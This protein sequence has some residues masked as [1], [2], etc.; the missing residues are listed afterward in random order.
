MLSVDFLKDFQSSPTARRILSAFSFAKKGEQLLLS[1]PFKE[2][3]SKRMLHYFSEAYLLD[4][5]VFQSILVDRKKLETVCNTVFTEDPTCEDALIAQLP[6]YGGHPNDLEQG[7]AILTTATEVMETAN[8]TETE[9]ILKQSRVYVTLGWLQYRK[10]YYESSLGSFEKSMKIATDDFTALLGAA[11]CCKKLEKLSD[12][13]RLHLSFLSKAS[14]CHKQYP[15][16]CYGIAEINLET[17]DA[18]GFCYY[19]EKGLESEGVRLPFLPEVN[20]PV[21]TRLL[22]FYFATRTDHLP[23]CSSCL[24]LEMNELPLKRCC[25]VYY[26]NK[27]VLFGSVHVSACKCM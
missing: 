1:D 14:K 4:T 22:G 26:C 23:F 11:E 6:L 16:A 27:L 13:R 20:L 12:S 9:K 19:F 21:K 8:S 5:A 2:S 24:Q 7:I 18:P 15:R 3:D 17:L 25:S 10:R